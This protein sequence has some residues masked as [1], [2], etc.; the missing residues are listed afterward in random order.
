MRALWSGEVSFGL[1]SVPVKLYSATKSHDVSLHQV[2]DEDGGRIRYERRC[3]V[4]GRVIDY[5]DIDR[6]YDDGDK[7]VVITKEE[8]AELPA[9]ES[10]E[11]AV[12]QFV[13]EEQIDSMILD[14]SYFLEPASKSSKS[15]VLLRRTLEEAS[16]VAI[17]TFTLRSKTRLAALRVRDD[18]IVL[19]TMRW[20]DEMRDADF[21]IPS[22]RISKKE[23]EMAASLVEAYS[24]DF[25]P[26]RF[27]DAYQEQL[28]TLIEEKLE[29][30]EDIDTEATFGEVDEDEGDGDVIDLMEAL[31]RS[32]DSR[33]GRR[34]GAS[35]S[36]A[37][38]SG[39]SGES[40]G[41]GARKKSSS[42]KAG[43]A[44]KSGGSGSDSSGKSG[45]SGKS[46]GVKKSAAGAKSNSG[47]KSSAKSGSKSSGSTSSKSKASTSSGKSASSKGPK[48]AS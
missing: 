47:K 21:D 27:T 32:V 15:Y 3:E 20:A 33:R 40:A 35:G 46:A 31:K 45:G 39:G 36:G 9:D 13:P 7:T 5:G 25:E 4:C 38:G 48:K 14:K 30:G 44:K 18:V 37:S 22:S 2:H 43:G 29:H 8:L 42:G 1:V 23:M 24:E 10:R 17:V 41:S 16:R 34:S 6:A 11:I 26:E 28:Q 19:Q 12:E